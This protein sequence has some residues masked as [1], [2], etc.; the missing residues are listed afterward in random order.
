MGSVFSDLEVTGLL[1]A[2]QSE[3]FATAQGLVEQPSA[4]APAAIVGTVNNYVLPGLG[5]PGAQPMLWTITGS[6]TPVINGISVGDGVQTGQRICLINAAG[7]NSVSI[8]A[9]AGASLAGNQ[10]AAAA[11]IAVGAAQHFTYNGTN[12]SPG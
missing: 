7:S 11:T 4:T 6:E 10:F 9:L 2:G 8:A 5:G 1:R 3:S 12:W